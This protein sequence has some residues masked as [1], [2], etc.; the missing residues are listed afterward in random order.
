MWLLRFKIRLPLP[1][2]RAII[3]FIVG[4]SPTIASFTT[5]PSTFRFALFS[6]F[7]TALFNVLLISA[8]AFFG[9]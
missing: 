6:A 4:P 9:L 1:R 5:R 8:A 2:A 3:R 7:A